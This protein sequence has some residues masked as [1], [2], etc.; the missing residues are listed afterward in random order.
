MSAVLSPITKADPL[1]AA[2]HAFIAAKRA[3]DLAVKHRRELEERILALEP[4]K[5]EGSQTIEVAGYKLTTTCK[6]TYKCDDVKALAEA[7]SGWPANMVPVKTEIKLDETGAKWLRTNE[8][9]AWRTLAGY[10]TVAPAKTA[11][12]VAV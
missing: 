8:P 10:I 9:D 6:L 4:A 11:L 1:E 7:C 2:V 3:E 12:K 5:D